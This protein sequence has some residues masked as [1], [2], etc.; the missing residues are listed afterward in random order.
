MIRPHK[1]KPTGPDDEI[2][3]TY[4]A[5][6]RVG[7]M[8]SR[9]RFD[10]YREAKEWHD[11]EMT[12]LRELKKHPHL[13]KQAHTF[14]EVLD[15]YVA[16][17]PERAPDATQPRLRVDGKPLADRGLKTV[18]TRVKWWREHYGT[19]ML[20]QLSPELFD[21][22]RDALAAETFTRGKPG[23]NGEAPISRTRHCAALPVGRQRR[24]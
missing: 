13:R 2:R 7:D 24:A 17:R 14:A 3:T 16:K 4:Y 23:K 18:D 15:Y 10:K 6:L 1:C 19:V 21:T 12:R 8:N 22:A 5:I 20:D 9:R 11:K